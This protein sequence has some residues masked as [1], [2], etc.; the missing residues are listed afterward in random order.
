MEGLSQMTNAGRTTYKVER[1][2]EAVGGLGKD[3]KLILENH[4]PHINEA[5]VAQ[6]AKMNILTTVNVGAIILYAL[7]TQLFSK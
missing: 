5:I 6:N 7:M 3:M 1:L 4:L 2:E